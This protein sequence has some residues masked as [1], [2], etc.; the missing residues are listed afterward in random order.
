MLVLAVYALVYLLVGDLRG[1][2]WDRPWIMAAPIIL[3]ALLEAVL[4][5]VQYY[6]G[7]D[8]ATGTYVNPNHFA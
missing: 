5:L 1:R 7:A 3:I 2:A 6:G 4:G 8:G